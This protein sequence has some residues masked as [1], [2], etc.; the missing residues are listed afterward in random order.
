MDTSE[1]YIEMCSKA[2]EI[3]ELR[4]VDKSYNEGDFLAESKYCVSVA[5]SYPSSL[6]YAEDGFM[7]QIEQRES[8]EIWLPRQD[9]LQEMVGIDKK[10]SFNRVIENFYKFAESTYPFMDE[11]GW[12]SE[13]DIHH[14]FEQLWLAFVMKENFEKEWN[15]DKKDWI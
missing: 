9:Q 10:Y 12:K 3:Q 13:G 6:E 1:K 15:E 2:T 11:C 14:S 4:K 5:Y 8:H 7:D